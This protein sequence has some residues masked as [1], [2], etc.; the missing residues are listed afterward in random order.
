MIQNYQGFSDCASV[1]EFIV[2]SHHNE[3]VIAIIAIARV[4]SCHLL[5]L[6]MHVL[7]CEFDDVR[8]HPRFSSM[9]M[10]LWYCIVYPFEK[11]WCKMFQFWNDRCVV[12]VMTI[13]IILGC[14][15]FTIRRKR[16]NHPIIH[17]FLKK[18]NDRSL[19]CFF[20]RT[21]ESHDRLPICIVVVD[22]RKR[23]DVTFVGKKNCGITDIRVNWCNRSLIPQWFVLAIVVAP[24]SQ[25]SSRV[26]VGSRR[27][28]IR[29][30]FCHCC[31]QRPRGGWWGANRRYA[32]WQQRW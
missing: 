19:V 6:R 28:S 25:K 29:Q 23:R 24:S 32:S 26:V 17:L 21:H 16:W 11:L 22:G 4:W 5:V 20:G 14:C 8:C 1:V 18:G 7:R 2:P 9:S 13:I 12:F 3:I 30:K 27:N 31:L 15:I 10:K